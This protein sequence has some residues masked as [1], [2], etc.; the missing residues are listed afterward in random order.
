VT[1]SLLN[2]E[3]VTLQ[4]EGENVKALSFADGGVNT[5]SIGITT[6]PD[7][8]QSNPDLVRRFVGASLRGWEEAVKNPSEAV[9]VLLQSYPSYK[10]EVVGQSLAATIP[11][12]HTRSTEGKP[13]GWMAREDWQE[14]YDLLA[15]AGLVQEPVS[16]D[17]LYTNDFVPSP[18]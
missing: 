8:I 17:N 9:D 16:V 3:V 4:V 1:S 14:T 7:L 12:L 18:R 11:L 10:A 2:D 6:H 5:V 15:K 13:L